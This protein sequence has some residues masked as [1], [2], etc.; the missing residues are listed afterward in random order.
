MAETKTN[1][2]HWDLVMK[3]RTRL[4]DLNFKE[5]FHYREQSKSLYDQH[6]G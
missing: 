3:A 5:L 2:E 6:R 1:D 4:F